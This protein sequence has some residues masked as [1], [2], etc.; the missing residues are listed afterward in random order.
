[1]SINSY[2]FVFLFLPLTLVLYFILGYF[3]KFKLAQ[4]L[5]ICASLVFYAYA[6]IE[7][8]LLFLMSIVLNYLFG[9]K[10][11]NSKNKI[12]L[13]LLALIINIGLLFYFK[14]F[15]FTIEII[16]SIFNK[17]MNTINILIPLGISFFTFQQLAYIIDCY[18][19]TVDNYS[20][21]DYVSYI[22][23]FPQITAGPITLHN[24]MIPQFRDDK[25]KKFNI[26]NFSMGLYA[27]SFGLVKKV[28]FADTFALAANIVFNG[29]S[30]NSIDAIIGILSYTFQIYFDFSGYCD[31]GIGIS[32]MFNIE[33]PLNFD[34]PYKSYSIVEFW[35]K[36]HMT[37]TRFFTYY[38][39][40][41]LGGSRKGT[42]RT[43]A[44]IIIIFLISGIWHGANYTFILWGL[45]HGLASIF[46][47]IFKSLK[48]KWHPVFNWF[49]TFAWINVCWTFFRAN[50]IQ[51][52]INILK[53]SVSFNFGNINTDILDA[54][55]IPEFKFMKEQ[56]GVLNPYFPIVIFF[57]FTFFAILCMKNTTERLKDFKP[58]VKNAI[59]TA[60]LFVWGI[61]SVTG[62]QT[63]IYVNF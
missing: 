24:E 47:R 49:I 4:I 48:E 62:V 37:L 58:T 16:N 11:K 30:I 7:F 10:I 60:L 3:K 23:F 17:S 56:L 39:Y 6:K 14:Y 5:L 19:E 34:S 38:I 57:V 33:L 22:A 13:L 21:L 46:D 55:T 52:A 25:R 61:I 45:L 36:W 44:N 35:K 27:F 20:F 59:I 2:L 54:F 41:P 63:F 15:N 18:K 12:I 26:E 51:S 31:M 53:S 9:K 43:Y 8:T 50:S 28:I 40:I 1:M 42:V 32:K 29:Q